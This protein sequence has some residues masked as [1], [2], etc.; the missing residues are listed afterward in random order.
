MIALELLEHVVMPVHYSSWHITSDCSAIVIKV[1]CFPKHDERWLW[2]TWAG[3]STQ[4]VCFFTATSESNN[5]KKVNGFIKWWKSIN[6]IQKPTAAPAFVS[7]GG[8]MLAPCVGSNWDF[9]KTG[10][11]GIR[12]QHGILSCISQWTFKASIL[13][14][15]WAAADF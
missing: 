9:G 5:Q 10:V 14:G 1:K 15:N 4:I 6:L 7:Y 8:Q 13:N 2:M 11:G 3:Q 12:S